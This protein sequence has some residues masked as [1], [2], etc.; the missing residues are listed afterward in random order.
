MKR[1]HWDNLYVIMVE[2]EEFTD[3]WMERFEALDYKHK[4]VFTARE[5]PDIKS[6]YYIPGSTQSGN[7]VI[8][9]CLYKSKLSGRRWLDE[10]DYVSFLNQKE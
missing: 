6:A 10:F 8:D 4:V 3:E 1:V 7:T 5:R 9:L 2:N